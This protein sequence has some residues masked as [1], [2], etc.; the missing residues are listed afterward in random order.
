MTNPEPTPYKSEL[1][2][3][4]DLVSEDLYSRLELGIKTYKTPLQ[5]HNGRDA[6]R[7]VYEELLDAACYIRQAL[8]ERDGR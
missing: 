3:I 2:I 7:D 1:P 6:L 4:H 8:Y 5:P